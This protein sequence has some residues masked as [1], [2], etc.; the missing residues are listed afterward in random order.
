MDVIEAVLFDLDDTLYPQ[1]DWLRGCWEAVAAEASA[2]DGVDRDRLHRALVEIASEGS[3]RGRI[4]DR[5]L[6]AIGAEHVDVGPLVDAV[7]AHRPASLECYPG[8]REAV[9][10]IRGAVPVALVTDGD[11]DLQRAKLDLL[12]LGSAF[13]AIVFSDELGREFR[14]P[15]PAP[16]RR[17]LELL[18]SA[19][20]VGVMVGDRPDKDVA[21]AAMA[22]LR[23]V[24][25]LT[26]EYA[27]VPDDAPP[28]RTADA[29]ASVPALLGPLLGSPAA[30]RGSGSVR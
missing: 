25:V 14:K 1:Q 30:R 13:D 18:G 23:T 28:W 22:G 12:G 8:A 3:D 6:A 29:I 26:G 19:P 20:G 21:G 17:A 11:P 4:I 16:F 27:H 5:A 10:E 7:L 24:R 2:R 9:A 15:N